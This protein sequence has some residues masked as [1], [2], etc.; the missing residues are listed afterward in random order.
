[1]CLLTARL[2]LFGFITFSKDVSC[3]MDDG[4][5]VDLVRFDVIYNA[6]RPLNHFAKLKKF[7]FWDGATGKRMIGNLL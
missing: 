7:V 1:M 5:H 6:V 2:W 3:A 4:D